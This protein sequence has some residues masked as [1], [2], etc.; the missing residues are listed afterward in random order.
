MKNKCI[1]LTG[2]ALALLAM[3]ASVQA[4]PISGSIELTGYATPTG[5]V[6]KNDFSTATSILTEACSVSSSTGTFA[7]GLS[8]FGMGFGFSRYGIGVNGNTPDPVGMV[9]WSE[10]LLTRTQAIR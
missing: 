8:V 10:S 2:A 3:T 4:I 7:N 1:K 5:G 6:I 9:L